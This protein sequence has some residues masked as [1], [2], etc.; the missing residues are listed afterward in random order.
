[1]EAAVNIVVAPK[2]L[3]NNTSGTEPIE[4]RAG[5]EYK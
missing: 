3:K 1:M 5:I 2:L 4:V